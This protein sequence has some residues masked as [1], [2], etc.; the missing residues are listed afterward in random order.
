MRQRARYR[1]AFALTFQ[2]QSLFAARPIDVHVA[3]FLS[4]ESGKSS[5]AVGW[6]ALWQIEMQEPTLASR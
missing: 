6:R 2:R 1:A 3:T 5:K 4:F